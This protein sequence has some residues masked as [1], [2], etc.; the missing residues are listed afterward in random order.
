MKRYIVEPPF[1]SNISFTSY[2][3]YIYLFSFVLIFY[4]QIG[5][6]NS[7]PSPIFTY[8]VSMITFN[9]FLLV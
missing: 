5:L 1:P 7:A 9:I 8:S 2:L 4:F 6:I 3:H